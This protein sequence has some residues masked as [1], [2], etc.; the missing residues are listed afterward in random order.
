MGAPPEVR[1]F[2]HPRVAGD[3]AGNGVVIGNRNTIREY[4]QVH[5]GWKSRTELGDDLFI[6]NRAYIAHDCVVGNGVTLASS[7]LLAGHV[8]VGAGA[9]LGL[10][11]AVH[12][13]VRSG[14]RI[15]VGVGSVVAQDIP[16]FA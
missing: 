1:G 15:M 16:P 11:V 6:M 13:R 2:D 9:N 5:Q 8:S 4:A 12:Q 14:A 7:V 3:P 10:G